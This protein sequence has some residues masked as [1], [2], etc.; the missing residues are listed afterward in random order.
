MRPGE[1]TTRRTTTLSGAQHMRNQDLGRY[2]FISAAALAMLSGCGG[3]QSQMTPAAAPAVR[4]LADHT[5]TPACKGSRIGRAQC[6]VL[7]ENKGAHPTYNGWTASELEAAYNLPTSDG[8]GQNVFIV[9]AYDNPD[10]VS[11]FA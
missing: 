8:S 6:D 4:G 5:A 2:A 10:V 3:S 11:N 9:D 1:Q 7:I